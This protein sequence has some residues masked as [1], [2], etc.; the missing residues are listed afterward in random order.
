MWVRAHRVGLVTA[1]S[2][3]IIALAAGE[4]LAQRGGC[5]VSARFNA[6]AWFRMSVPGGSG[7]STGRNG[8]PALYGFSPGGGS[9]AYRSAALRTVGYLPS[10]LSTLH[11]SSPY[12]GSTGDPYGGYLHGAADVIGSQ[13]RL[14]VSQQ[15]ALLSAGSVSQ[16]RLETRRREFD[17]WLYERANRPTREDDRDRVQQQE[18]RRSR[19]DPPLTEIYSAKPLNDLLMELQKLH[20][21]GVQPTEVVLAEEVVRQV[22]VTTGKG[23]GHAGILKDDGR[24]AWPVA[25]RTYLAREQRQRVEDLVQEAISQAKNGR[26]AAAALRDLDQTFRQLNQDLREAVRDIPPGQFI[27]AK[28]FLRHLDDALRVLQQPDAANHFNG[29]YTARG[30]SVAELVQ[31]M[32]KE[33]LRFAPAVAGDEAAYIALHRALVAYE[34]QAQVVILAER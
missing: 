4:A 26:Q 32:T 5:G 19:N 28:R 13:G 15:Q 18:L 10:G 14:L 23:G 20:G 12:D 1:L 30:K 3:V 34:T 6:G 7:A 16:A 25:L 9:F 31:H 24:L 29:K 11:A 17:E 22:D 27:E 21:R 2:C 8:Q 33:G